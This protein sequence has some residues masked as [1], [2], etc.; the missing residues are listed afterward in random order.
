MGRALH[1]RLILALLASGLVPCF[2][3]DR[4][5]EVRSPHFSVVTDAGQRRGR[6]VALRFEQMRAVFGTLILRSKVNIPV[7]LQIVAFKSAGGL[8]RFVPLWKGKPVELAG[9]YQMGEDRNFIALDL[10]ANQGLRTVFHEYAH[11]LLNGNYPRTQLWF[12]EGFAEYYSTIEVRNKEVEIGRPPASARLLLETSLMPLA[13]LFAVTQNSQTYN[14][15]GDRRTLFYAQSWLVVHYLFDTGKLKETGTYFDLVLNQHVPVPEAI[16]RAFGMEPKQFDRQIGVY[17]HSSHLVAHTFE[18]PAG[19]DDAGYSITE[20]EEADANAVLADLHLH[21]PQY[22]EQ[23]VQEFEAVLQL[24]PNHAAAHRGLGYAYLR[25]SQF[26]QAGEHFRRASELDSTDARVH[27][28]AALLMNLSGRLED[29]WA[30]KKEAETAISLAPEFADA[31]NLLAIANAAE[32]D[33]EAAVE[34]M[35]KAVRLSPRSDLYLLNLAQYSLMA[36]KWDDAAALFERLKASADPRLAALAAQ[37]LER[38]PNMKSN[39][40]PLPVRRERPTDWSQYDEPQWR[41]RTPSPSPPAT[42]AR[43]ETPPAQ[44]DTRP[45]KF[46]KGKL[47]QVDCSQPPAAVLTVLSGKRTWKLRAA[48]SSTLVL[49]GTGAFSCA[50]RNRDVAVNY[51][52]GGQSDGDLVSLELD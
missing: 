46:L 35:K 19:I 2:A 8:R 12:D 51:R 42:V 16:Q 48:D 41:R 18:A 34:A 49:V 26:E 43:K 50:W 25:K 14:E 29:P 6:E 5:I 33:L 17:A 23:A 20:L 52:E 4:W 40:P 39:P 13:T 10:S 27:Y 22:A 32:G 24:N 3:A 37:N 47:L 21:S 30:M 7:P 38:I 15:S 28:Y 9:F 31:Y 45:I 36:R 44:P 11:L 1:R